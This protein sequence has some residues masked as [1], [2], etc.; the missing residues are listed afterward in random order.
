MYNALHAR[1]YVQQH[2]LLLDRTAHYGGVALPEEPK[3]GVPHG[4]GFEFPI[5]SIM[6]IISLIGLIY[7]TRAHEQKVIQ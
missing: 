5:H 4:C 3:N 1:Q 6:F 7:S 2:Q